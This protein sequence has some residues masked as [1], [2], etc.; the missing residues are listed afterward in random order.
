MIRANTL[1]IR[2]NEL[3]IAAYITRQPELRVQSQKLHSQVVEV[4]SQA[5]RIKAQTSD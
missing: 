2:A 3:S 5:M 4:V 1:L